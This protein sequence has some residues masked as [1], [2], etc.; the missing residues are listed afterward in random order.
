MAVITIDHIK[1]Q[2]EYHAL[3][4]ARSRI[5]WVLSV[6]TFVAYF[7]LI[8]FIAFSPDSLGTP[9]GTGVTSI[10]MVL[11]LGVIFLCFLVTGIYVYYAN[12]VLEPLKRAVIAKLGV[13]E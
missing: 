11:G 7:A 8:L 6:V 3:V 10:G 12:R 4:R 1:H 9:I 2:P 5:T 13:Q